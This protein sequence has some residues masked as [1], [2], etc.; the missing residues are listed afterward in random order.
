MRSFL[1]A[2]D[3]AFSGLSA[4]AQEADP[5][6]PDPPRPGEQIKKPE[7]DD[8]EGVENQKNIPTYR[9][10]VTVV[11]VLFNVKE[12]HGALIPNLAKEQF[13]LFEEGKPQT[14][15]YFSNLSDQPL[16]VGLLIDS[17]Y[18]MNRTLPEE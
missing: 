2:L 10:N 7:P 8:R 6:K 12:K 14:I 17:S 4:L 16:T 11:N 1:L 9:K 18:S 5:P 15:K 3:L 13:E